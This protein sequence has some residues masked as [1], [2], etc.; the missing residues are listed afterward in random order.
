M[1]NLNDRNCLEQQTVICRGRRSTGT[2]VNQY[3]KRYL[4]NISQNNGHKEATIKGEFRCF[5]KRSLSVNIP[6]KCSLSVSRVPQL[7]IYKNDVDS[8]VCVGNQLVKTVVAEEVVEEVSHSGSVLDLRL[9]QQASSHVSTKED[10]DNDKKIDL[11]MFESR[12][13]NSDAKLF[14]NGKV[15]HEVEKLNTNTTV[16]KKN[17]KENFLDNRKNVISVLIEKVTKIKTTTSEQVVCKTDNSYC[18]CK[19]ENVFKNSKSLGINIYFMNNIKITPP[20][21]STKSLKLFI[22][23]TT[24]S[25]ILKL[26]VQTFVEQ[27]NFKIILIVTH[28]FIVKNIA[29]QLPPPQPPPLLH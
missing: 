15:Q 29:K 21:E 20:Q 5:D 19:S 2:T 6:D 23:N 11:T 13:S 9:Y 16:I 22:T 8:T 7:E 4:E 18:E 27:L 14:M 26:I 3:L 12:K 28:L 24:Y 1:E 17:L 25:P 10:E